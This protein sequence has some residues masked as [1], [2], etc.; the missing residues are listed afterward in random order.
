[1]TPGAAPV[2]ADV[3]RLAGVS[4]QTVSRVVNSSPKVS[5][6]TRARVLAAMDEL[7]YRPNAIA[8][9]LARRHTGIIGVI[10]FETG[11]FGPARTVTAVEHAARAVGLGLT[12]TRALDDSPDEVT[13]ALHRLRDLAAEGVVV[14]ASHRTTIGAVGASPAALPAVHIGDAV[15]GIEVG[16]DGYRGA[17]T[18][19]GHLLDLRHRTVHHISGPEG[20]IAADNRLA[21]W[22]GTLAA[23]QRPVV[24]P[25]AG[26]WS[27]ASG[28]AA[29]IDLL[30]RDP[31]LTAVF[32]ANDQMALGALRAIQD[33]G[34]R[35]PA[36]VSVVGLDD[37]PEA[38]YFGPPLT[39]LAQP[40]DA[41]GQH[42]VRLLTERLQDCAADPVVVHASLVLR[43]STAPPRA[44]G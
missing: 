9:A 17:A 14:V 43:G 1:M 8:R 23:A 40:F 5:E 18:A 2:M 22:A 4:H 27:A 37:L 42:A 25:S 19:T 38:P 3:A 29:M 16:I 39:T 31:A 44:A 11:K 28:H 20:W 36:D 34:R 21:G 26:D 30:E 6:A 10:A 13:R 7:G 35:V 33:S 24:A 41:A 15:A 12:V 32:V